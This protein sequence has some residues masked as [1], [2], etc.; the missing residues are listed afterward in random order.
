MR[1]VRTARSGL[2]PAAHVA[3]STVICAALAATSALPGS[4]CKLRWPPAAAG[5]LFNAAVSGWPRAWGQ[6]LPAQKRQSA[7]PGIANTRC[8]QTRADIC[9]SARAPLLHL[10]AQL[11]HHQDGLLLIDVGYV[12]SKQRGAA[13]G[14][15]LDL[16]PISVIMKSAGAQSVLLR[17]FN[18]F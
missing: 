18:N 6:S 8:K 2:V 14:W 12:E 13:I 1:S 9:S 5:L 4:R 16:P 7:G 10:T 3:S 17:V 11:Q 15:G